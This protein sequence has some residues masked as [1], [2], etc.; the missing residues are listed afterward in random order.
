MNPFQLLIKP[1][2]Y[3]CNLQCSYCFYLRVCETVYADNEKPFMNDT[4]LEEMIAQYMNYRFP[5]SI[6][7]WQGGEPTLMGL[8]FFQKVISLQQKYGSPGQVV[9]NALQTNGVLINEKWARF[10]STFKFLVGL[11][12]DGPKDIH[13]RYRRTNKRRS[14]WHEV[15]NA[16]RLF[17]AHQVQFNILCV[18]SKANVNRVKEVYEFF[19]K[20]GFF[21]MQF[22]PALEADS[23]GKKASF[24]IN[25]NQYGK[26]LCSLFDL[27]KQNPNLVSIRTFDA[28]LSYYLGVPKGSCTFEKQ[29][30][31]YLLIEY[32]GDVYPCD[33]FVQ[34]THKIGNL[35]DTELHELFEMRNK[36]FGTRKS[37]LSEDCSKCRWL[38][39]C[40]GGCIKDRI[41]SDNPHPEKTYFCDAYSQFFEHTSKW[42]QTQA[43]LIKS[44]SA[45]KK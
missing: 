2:S 17:Q 35:L 11:S 3:R 39:L 27:W 14:M 44:R 30:A 6:F 33:F 10:L 1:A 40:Y 31:N 5:E 13:D 22:I 8:P 9:G 41:F 21:Y 12:L 42:F 38:H 23:K 20:N 29:C 28:L 16:A 34:D 15:M 45:L 37:K 43:K 36:S 32:N 19:V 7:G 4:V 25:S 18:V 24:C 26:F